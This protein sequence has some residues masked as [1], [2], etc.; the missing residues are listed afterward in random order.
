M[1]VIRFILR[2]TR[3]T[4]FWL[5]LIATSAW[6][7]GALWYDVPPVGSFRPVPLLF[8]AGAAAAL[9]LVRPCWLAGL[10]VLLVDGLIA[11]WWFSL[12]PSNDRAWQPNVAETPWAQ[13][14]G[15]LITLHNVRHCD[16]RTQDDYSPRWETRTFHLSQLTGVDLALTFWGSEWM[17][18]P[19]LSF[20][21]ADAPPLAVS[22]ETRKETG[23]SYSAIGGLYRQ[24]ELI[25]VAAD[26]RDVLRLR[27]NYRKGE[28]VYLYR[29]TLSAAAARERLIEYL[30]TMNELREHPRWYHA[31]TTNCTTAVRAQ[32]P[33]TRRASW[34]WRILINGKI[35]Q[36]FHELGVLASDGLPFAELKRRA[37]INPAAQ[38]AD[39]SPDFSQ[40]IRA[41]R[42]G[43]GG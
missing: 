6:A 21:F 8:A 22:I 1:Q 19:I 11:M 24:F 20:R 37:L 42:P 34:D 35:D 25:Y 30:R 16:Y 32:R 23:E 33:V 9:I 27:T 10:G 13:V 38:E 40:R 17:S 28:Q 36:L 39:Q 12:D 15:D 2:A 18:H 26:E 41:G 5:L 43:F 31:V 3:L 14:E 29:T 7:F 4:F